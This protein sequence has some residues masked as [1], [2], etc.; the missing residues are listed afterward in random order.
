MAFATRGLT[1][2]SMWYQVSAVFF[3]QLQA[4]AAAKGVGWAANPPLPL[5]VATQPGNLLLFCMPRGD[6]LVRAS[7]VNPEERRMRLVIGCR[8]LT[9]TSLQDADA[10]HF[11]A[12]DLVKSRPFRAALSPGIRGIGAMR[13]VELEPEL[14][15]IAVQGSVLMSA[16][17]IDYLQSYPSL[18]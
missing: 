17:E 13:E 18:A 4:L 7:N 15:D 8:A 3:G 16:Y 14:K 10:L 11:A 6:L 12:R 2:Q 1:V 9:S 5:D